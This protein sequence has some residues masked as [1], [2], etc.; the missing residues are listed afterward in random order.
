MTFLPPEETKLVQSI[1]SI[2]EDPQRSKDLLQEIIKRDKALDEKKADVDRYFEEYKSSSKDL[3]DKK[4]AA[5]RVESDQMV[6]HEQLNHWASDLRSKAD[7]A[8]QRERAVAQ[9][10]A[11]V[12]AREKHHIDVSTSK[13]ASLA[14]REKRIKELEAQHAKAIEETNSRKADYEAK[15]AR[16]KELV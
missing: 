15:I 8:D 16:L 6:R 7:Q 4:Q 11:D 5:L 2:L 14:D 10:E 13:E 1:W 3:E 12:S 9:R